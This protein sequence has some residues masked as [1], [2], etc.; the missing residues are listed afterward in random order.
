MKNHFYDEIIYK[1]FIYFNY[2]Y[3]L[4]QS[5]RNFNRTY[6][7]APINPPTM[8]HRNYNML[9][10]AVPTELDNKDTVLIE[11]FPPLEATAKEFIIAEAVL[12]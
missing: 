5:S 2:S 10:T 3:N 11:T 6:E 1:E 7:P 9:R 8:E 12:P 4:Y